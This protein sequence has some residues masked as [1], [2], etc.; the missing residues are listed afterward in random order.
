MVRLNG[1]LNVDGSN[2][3]LRNV[4]IPITT[5][6]DEHN[7]MF[8]DES[9]DYK[10]KIKD[11][12]GVIREIAKD[13]SSPI[14]NEN[15]FNPIIGA[16][17]NNNSIYVDEGDGYT[18]NFK[19]NDGDIYNI[20]PTPDVYSVTFIP[21]STPPAKNNSLFIDDNDKFLKLKNDAGNIDIV[22]SGGGGASDL[23][24]SFLA[25]A[26]CIQAQT[27]TIDG[28]ILNIHNANI[29]INNL[30]GSG[31]PYLN[32]NS[33]PPEEPVELW[34][35]DNSD[36]IHCVAVDDDQNVYIGTEDSNVIKL[37]ST[38]TPVWTFGDHMMKVLGIDVDEF[39][40]VYSGS[41]D[42]NVK[43]INSSGIEQW[44]FAGHTGWVNDVKVDSAGNVY[45]A[46]SDNSVR[47]LSNAGAEL[48]AYAGH[49]NWVLGV[50][51]D[52]AG[53]VYTASADGTVR[54]MNDS[55]THQWTFSD[56]SNWVTGIAIDSNDNIYTCSADNTV[57]R[58]DVDGNEIW[59]FSDHSNN[60]TSIAIDD[61]N[62]IYTGSSST[63]IIKI[64]S[65]AEV[66]W[67]DNTHT[68]AVE[69]L[70]TDPSNILYTASS[71]NKTRKIQT[72]SSNLG[73][74]I[75]EAIVPGTDK[76]VQLWTKTGTNNRIFIEIDITDTDVNA[77]ILQNNIP[78]NFIKSFNDG[79]NVRDYN[80]A[81]KYVHIIDD[82]TY[83]WIGTAGQNVNNTPNWART[84]TL[85]RNRN[86]NSIAN[87]YVISHGNDWRNSTCT[88]L[89]QYAISG[90]A[91]RGV[92]NWST[93]YRHAAGDW[94]DRKYYNLRNFTHTGAGSSIFQTTSF[95]DTNASASSYIHSS[96]L[97]YYRF[98]NEDRNSWWLGRLW[99]YRSDGHLIQYLN[100]G[101]DGLGNSSMVFSGD[102][103][104]LRSTSVQNNRYYHYI[105]A[106][107][108]NNSITTVENNRE[109]TSWRN[110]Y[111]FV[112][113]FDRIMCTYNI[114]TTR[115]LYL[116]NGT[117]MNNYSSS[118]VFNLGFENTGNFSI[119]NQNKYNFLKSGATVRVMLDDTETRSANYELPTPLT[120]VKSIALVNTV[121]GV[122]YDLYNLQ[123]K[124]TLS[125]EAF[126]GTT[127]HQ[128]QQ[129]SFKTLPN[130]NITH[131][132]CSALYP[133]ALTGTMG[134]LL[135][136]YKR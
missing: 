92:I 73:S 126:D 68:G 81:L 26:E 83:I 86:D 13:G 114:G 34:E 109:V 12:D 41:A 14:F 45:T 4:L 120:N 96:G 44:N 65:D 76:I 47:K 32:Y 107:H 18:L 11:N 80:F 95:R 112:R 49:T 90:N 54:K 118:N 6:P 134:R 16:P 43:K 20:S 115:Y 77:E 113:R 130:V 33:L 119:T 42:T 75:S 84:I 5:E 69:G 19:N 79:G 31:H 87:E 129:Y 98:I 85:V 53:N 123:Q 63:E 28:A 29:G 97:V 71:D 101:N 66:I 9:D 61:N 25:M 2:I 22:G 58:L 117:S 59:T 127:W 10:L 8:V 23:D 62:D 91:I 105:Y 15:I 100:S 102:V 132:R 108:A 1:N 40:N 17:P 48:W 7:A 116:N 37:D 35:Y 124:A 110:T 136:F 52:S 55:G 50:A 103:G 82:D 135:L 27:Y 99:F 131:V 125:F 133:I 104:F 24:Y 39:G 64:N 46:S 94:D 106:V 60:V 122:E 30:Q 56:H 88:A 21:T 3:T 93:V 67:V 111:S 121:H 78:H 51:T 57:K 72:L 89:S 38:G 36:D 74:L 128:F 70:A